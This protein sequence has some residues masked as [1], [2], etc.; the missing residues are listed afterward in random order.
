MITVEQGLKEKFKNQPKVLARALRAA[1][2]Q[3]R[4]RKEFRDLFENYPFSFSETK[5]GFK[6]W[7]NVFRKHPDPDP[8]QYLPDGY[9]D[10]EPIQEPNDEFMEWLESKIEWTRED[11]DLQREHWA[12][13]TAL[14]KYREIKNK[15]N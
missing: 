8:D 11:K 2:E 12:F 14:E 5:E 6:Y 4:L 15:E 10:A 1:R 3:G 9:I 7:F 13:C